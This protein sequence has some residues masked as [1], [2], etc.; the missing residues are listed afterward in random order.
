MSLL[1]TPSG[2]EIRKKPSEYFLENVYMTFQ[3]DW[4]AL[5]S[6]HMLNPERLLW[7]NDFPHPDSCWLESQSL[8]A[9]HAAHLSV[10][11][12]AHILHDNVMEVYR[13]KQAA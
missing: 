4:V 5:R 7:A 13:L 9:E 3:T 12:K 8:L 10:K 1:F 6:L 11:D 2:G